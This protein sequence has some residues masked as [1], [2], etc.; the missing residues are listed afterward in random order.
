MTPLPT[1]VFKFEPIDRN[2]PYGD[3][4]VLADLDAGERETD[5]SA[6]THRWVVRTSEADEMDTTTRLTTSWPLLRMYAVRQVQLRYR[7]SLLGVS[8]TLVQPVAI[9]AIYGFIFTRILDVSGEGIPYLSMAWSGLT[10]W[11]YVQA[12]VQMGCVS[13]LNDAY[14]IGKVWFP[15][16]IIPLAPVVGGLVDLGTAAIVLVPILMVQGGSF[17]PELLALPFLLVVLL[18]WVSAI[19]IFTATITI[20]LRDMATIIGLVMRLG[21]IATPVMYP[22][23]LATEQGLGWLISANPFAVVIDNLRAVAIAGVWPNWELLALHGV[24]GAGFFFLSLKYLRS[25]ERRMV[26]VI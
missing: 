20:F 18:L 23:S 5:H 2:K 16:E 14:M 9:M 8:W 3:R 25:V 1:P 19:S 13:L 11:M 22:A 4:K 7:Q 12:T 6:V 10:V 26:D 15:R 24:L 21:F 17:G